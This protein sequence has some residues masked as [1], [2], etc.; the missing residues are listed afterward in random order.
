[1]IN[2]RTSKPSPFRLAIPVVATAA[3]GTALYY[4]TRTSSNKIPKGE[5]LRKQRSTEGLSGAGLAG[6]DFPS[7]GAHKGVPH[8]DASRHELP[9]SGAIGAGEGGGKTNVRAVDMFQS[10]PSTGDAYP[11]SQKQQSG[12]RDKDKT[13]DSATAGAKRAQ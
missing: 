11:S 4:R 9:S 12:V 8:T 1:M 6:S 2:P 5:E 3:L 7:E 13:S 10:P